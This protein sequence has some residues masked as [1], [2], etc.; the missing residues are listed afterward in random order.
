MKNTAAI[1]VQARLGSK[2]FPYKT[3]KKLGNYRVI[4]WVIQRLK[5]SKKSQKIILATTLN[6]E[7]KILIDIARKNNIK[8]FRGSTNNCLLYTSPS[9]RDQRGSRMPSCG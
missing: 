6:S 3:I 7:D 5:Q 4:D 9:P 2:R 8:F 1:I